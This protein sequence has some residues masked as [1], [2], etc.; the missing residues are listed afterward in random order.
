[1]SRRVLLAMSLFGAMVLLAA[2]CGGPVSVGQP[3]PVSGESIAEAAVITC[4]GASGRIK[5]VADSTGTGPPYAFRVT[6]HDDANGGESFVATTDVVNGI[7]FEGTSA[8]PHGP[9]CI[10]V[11]I[12]G[13]CIPFSCEGW[14]GGT[15]TF[16]YTVSMVP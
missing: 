11:Q 2:G 4:P 7:H 1:M 15:Q 8:N 3:L 16:R 13:F 5:V 9:W 10:N 12:Q 6:V 14:I